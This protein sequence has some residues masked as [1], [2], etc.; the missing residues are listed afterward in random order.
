VSHFVQRA[1]SLAIG[2]NACAYTGSAAI[3]LQGGQTLFTLLGIPMTAPASNIS[4]SHLSQ[5][6]ITSLWVA[7][8]Y[9]RPDLSAMLFIDEVSLLTS[10][11]ISMIDK[12]LKEIFDS[13]EIFGGI[14]VILLGDFQQLDPVKGKSLPS[15]IV[16][17]LVQHAHA[18]RYVIGTP[19]EDGINLF[20]Q[21]QLIL[22][23][24]QMRASTDID[25]TSMNDQLRDTSIEKPVTQDIVQCLQRMIITPQDVTERPDFRFAP[26]AVCGNSERNLINHE[27]AYRF[28]KYHHRKVIQWRFDLV[29]LATNFPQHIIDY[30]HQHNTSSLTFLLLQA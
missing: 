27:Q 9:G 10:I 14:A 28:A 11:M 21:F 24:E 5:N 29:G 20:I 19:R 1:H 23:T 18:Y 22:L 16:E 6:S 7:F 8:R 25:H 17:H 15:S 2:T 4:L 3:N 30:I 13:S 26:V 12:R